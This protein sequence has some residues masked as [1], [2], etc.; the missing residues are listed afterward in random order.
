MHPQH[1]SEATYIDH[2]QEAEREM[3]MGRLFFCVIVCELN[4]EDERVT[5]QIFI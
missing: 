4:N 1:K 5:Q 2:Q 3:K